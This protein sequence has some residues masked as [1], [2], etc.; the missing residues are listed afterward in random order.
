[1]RAIDSAMQLA[2]NID[3]KLKVI[4]IN[5]RM[6]N[7]NFSDLFEKPDSIDL[8]EKKMIKYKIIEDADRILR[9]RFRF[10]GFR[11]PPGYSKY[12]FRDQILELKRNNYSFLEL[13]RYKSCLLC[14]QDRFYSDGKEYNWIRPKQD[15]VHAVQRVSK[16]FTDHTIGIHIR[17]TD[18]IKAIQQSPLELFVDKMNKVI[19]E[20]PH[21]NFFVATDS[22]E[23]E[24]KLKQVFGDR[25]ISI[26]KN[27]RRDDPKAI[28]DAFIDMLCLSRTSRIYGS[29]WSSFSAVAASI[30]RIELEIVQLPG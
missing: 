10:A 1:M 5:D 23:E 8:V 21:A 6:L 11:L 7:C 12:L 26:S 30:G 22:K 28:K 9:D 18:H 14:S 3:R 20:F 19:E 16:S 15:I 4:W 17:R 29:Y 25:I 24:N 13:K 27:Y 2:E